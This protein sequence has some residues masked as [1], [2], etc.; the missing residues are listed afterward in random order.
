VVGMTYTVRARHWERGWELHVE[1]VGVTQSRT[2]ARAEAMVRDYLRLDGHADWK[3]S[4]L[5]I[6]PDLDGLETRVSAA[7][8]L[9][10]S[11]E[12]AQR[13]AAR[14]ARAVA[15]ALREAG[16]SVSDTAAVLGVSRGRVSQLVS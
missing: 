16:L 1:G 13:D 5:V 9:T 3:T 6:A 4:D 8:E 15:R 10:R 11:A 12:R 14:E 7:R 2:L